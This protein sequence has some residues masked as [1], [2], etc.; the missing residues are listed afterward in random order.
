[1][2]TSEDVRRIL[3]GR[4]QRTG[5]V[6]GAA[7]ALA[8]DLAF[9]LYGAAVVG[10]AWLFGYPLP[11]DGFGL[12]ILI[13]ALGVGAVSGVWLCAQFSGSRVVMVVLIAWLAFW[14]AAMWQP[15]LPA[16]PTAWIAG[17]VCG[18]V[19]AVVALW[20]GRRAFDPSSTRSNSR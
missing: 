4:R 3:A 11:S 6:A 2:A 10:A 17:Y 12:A 9:V 7:A 14:I 1:M 16:M 15:V 19:G 5:R 20:S 13:A 18:H 8:L